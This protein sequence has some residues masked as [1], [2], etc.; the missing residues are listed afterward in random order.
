MYEALN[1]GIPVGVI[2]RASNSTLDV[3]GAISN[4]YATYMGSMDEKSI[5]VAPSIMAKNHFEFKE[6]KIEIPEKMK[7]S[8][9]KEAK[10]KITAWL[11]IGN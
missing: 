10:N 4:G 2:L 5:L 7:Q 11:K 8:A 6:S 9:Q 3:C 1:V